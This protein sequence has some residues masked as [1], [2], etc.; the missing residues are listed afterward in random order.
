MSSRSPDERSDIRD[1][2]GTGPGYRFAHPGY[3]KDSTAEEQSEAP[4]FHRNCRGQDEGDLEQRARREECED[5]G[6]TML[7]V[8][9]IDSEPGS[10]NRSLLGAPSI[11]R[12][13]HVS[14]ASNDPYA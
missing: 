11:A 13:L 3:G 2:A 10:G 8:G 7:P 1:F 5:V 12:G 4:G 6:H 14:S 9:A